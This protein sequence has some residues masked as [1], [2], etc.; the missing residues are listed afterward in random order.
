M[1]E[2]VDGP[3]PDRLMPASQEEVA[4]M[5]RECF[6]SVIIAAPRVDAFALLRELLPVIRPS[7]P[8]AVFGQSLQPLA[9]A[10]ALLQATKQFIS[11]Q[12]WNPPVIF[13]SKIILN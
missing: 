7:T 12:V 6:D 3:V 5:A 4:V 13:F 10:F 9:E 11:L 1:H 2:D 8:F